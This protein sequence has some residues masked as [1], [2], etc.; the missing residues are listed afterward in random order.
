[1]ISL[2]GETK[3]YQGFC[4]SFGSLSLIPLLLIEDRVC[5]K[6]RSNDKDKSIP[7]LKSCLDTRLILLL[8]K[9]SNIKI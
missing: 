4:S 7:A 8:L 9:I 5:H 3:A 1:V 2:Q 6:S